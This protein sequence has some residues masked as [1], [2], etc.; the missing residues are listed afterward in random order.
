MSY[1]S[2]RITHVELRRTRSF[3]RDRRS[4]CGV[5]KQFICT[6]PMTWITWL[7]VLAGWA[8]ITY[9]VLIGRG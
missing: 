6:L 8:V 2:R 9:L 3:C 7:V 5:I 4:K 1:C